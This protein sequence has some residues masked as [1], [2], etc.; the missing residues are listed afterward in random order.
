MPPKG[1]KTISLP[2]EVYERLMK[3]LNIANEAAGYRKYR[4]VGQFLEALL[5]EYEKTIEVPYFEHFNVYEDH[6]TIWDHRRKRLIDVFIRNGKLICEF[7]KSDGCEHVK[8][9]LTIPKVVETLNFQF[10]L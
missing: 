9:A 8:F 1:F 7:C 3:M 5:A 6:I 4:S 10:S 2:V